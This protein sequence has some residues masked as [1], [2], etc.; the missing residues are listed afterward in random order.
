[1]IVFLQRRGHTRLR[2]DKNGP[3]LRAEDTRYSDQELGYRLDKNGNEQP[4]PKSEPESQAPD[5]HF[6]DDEKLSFSKAEPTPEETKAKNQWA[7]STPL[8]PG[9]EAMRS[10]FLTRMRNGDMTKAEATARINKLADNYAKEPYKAAGPKPYVEPHPSLTPAPQ[11]A[12][13][14]KVVY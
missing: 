1:M 12:E 14:I 5:F 6:G 3:I 2:V 7:R 8:E 10:K 9:A 11:Q 4:L 13:Q